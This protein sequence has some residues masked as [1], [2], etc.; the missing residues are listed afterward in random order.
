[1]KML[2]Q[3]DVLLIRIEGSIPV[4]ARR[5]DGPGGRIVLAYGEATGHAHA[6]IGGEATVYES[7]HERFLE[8]RL[9]SSLIHEEHAA[10]DLEAGA[11]RIVRQ[12][13]YAPGEF[14]SVQD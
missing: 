10:L 11:Y 3:G 1:M 6:V 4:D 2:R 13:E 9:A 12:R 5:V 8:V 7:G 14:R